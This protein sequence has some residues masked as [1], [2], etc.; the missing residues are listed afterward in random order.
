MNSRTKELLRLVKRGEVDRYRSLESMYRRAGIRQCNCE[1][2][3]CAGSSDS[4]VWPEGIGLNP[5][6]AEHLG[7]PF[8]AVPGICV[9][10]VGDARVGYVGGLCDGCAAYMPLEFHLEDC[11]CLRCAETVQSEPERLGPN[12]GVGHG[13]GCECEQCE[14]ARYLSDDPDVIRFDDFDEFSW[15]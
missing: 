7:K 9:N 12:V 15:D 6:E 10:P 14:I 11:G 3:N 13:K 2:L 5:E 4:H 8:L 1:N